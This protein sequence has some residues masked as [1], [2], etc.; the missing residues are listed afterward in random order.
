MLIKGNN[1]WR[2]STVI[3]NPITISKWKLAKL[4]AKINIIKKICREKEE[5]GRELQERQGYTDKPYLKKKNSKIEMNIFPV[6]WIT[7]YKAY[8]ALLLS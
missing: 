4:T 5:K 3:G 6:L 2:T 7:G 1:Y 8:G